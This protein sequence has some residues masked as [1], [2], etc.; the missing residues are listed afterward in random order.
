MQ[1]LYPAI[2]NFH[3][4]LALLSLIGFTVRGW[5]SIQ[6]SALLQQRWVKITPHFIDTLLLLT[7]IALMII[8]GQHPG[9]QSWILAKI[10][11]LLFYIGFGTMAIKRAATQ[12]GKAVFFSLAIAT[13][14]YIVGV[15]IAHHPASWLQVF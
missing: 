11:A 1:E 12:T 8:L 6:G 3:M 4:S 15:A 14:C 9:N 13:F 7:A 5:W 10:I 2:R